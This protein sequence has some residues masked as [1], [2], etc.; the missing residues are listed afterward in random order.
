LGSFLPYVVIVT[1]IGISVSRNAFQF[2]LG[3][4][5][6]YVGPL[7]L[8][9]AAF[10]V[11]DGLILMG[12]LPPIG[13]VRSLT[14]LGSSIAAAIFIASAWTTSGWS[15]GG[16]V[17]LGAGGIVSLAGVLAGVVALIVRK[18]G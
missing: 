13:R 2:G 7:I 14:P 16:A 8:L 9:G 1:T 6:T 11:Y 10:F 5:L 17:H 4:T 15:G 18:T 3:G 12:V